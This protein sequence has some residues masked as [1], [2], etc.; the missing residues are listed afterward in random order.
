MAL[1][2]DMV[3][4]AVAGLSL[5][6]GYVI[7]RMTSG[8]GSKKQTNQIILATKIKKWKIDPEYSRILVDHGKN[9]TKFAESELEKLSEKKQRNQQKINATTDRFPPRCCFV[10]ISRF[11]CYCTNRNSAI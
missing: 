6:I 7:G 8:S 5:I 4:A 9:T 3:T 1:D 2:G 10:G 11:F